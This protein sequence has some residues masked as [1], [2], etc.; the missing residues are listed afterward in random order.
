MSEVQTCESCGYQAYASNGAISQRTA[1]YEADDGTIL[2]SEWTLCGACTNQLIRNPTPTCPY[3]LEPVLQ[4]EDPRE[5]PQR[6]KE[7]EA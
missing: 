6:P 5:C 1:E 7:A 4:D 2:S 3:C